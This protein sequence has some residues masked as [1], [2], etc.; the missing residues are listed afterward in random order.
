MTNPDHTG[1]ATL[2]FDDLLCSATPDELAALRALAPVQLLDQ[3]DA[4]AVEVRDAMEQLVAQ[5]DTNERVDMPAK[6]HPA[7]VRLGLINALVTWQAGKG[8]T[9]LHAPDPR[10][11]Q[12]VHAVAWKP[13]LVVCDL[14]PH[15]LAL[16]RNSTADHRCDGCGT[17]SVGVE[18]GG[19]IQ[20]CVVSAGPLTYGIGV[21]PDCCYWKPYQQTIVDPK[22]DH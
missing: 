15:L 3:F 1:R 21:C 4:A 20:G 12:P 9:C 14:C 2:A 8:S 17:V 16:P 6:G 22:E 11:P 10:F 7:W 19:G 18:N 13:G 5:G